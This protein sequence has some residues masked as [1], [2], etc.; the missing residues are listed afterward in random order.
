M[1]NSGPAM[2]RSRRKMAIIWEAVLNFA[3]LL[4]GMSILIF[5]RNSRRPEMKIS[6]Q[7]MTMTG[8]MSGSPIWW[9]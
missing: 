9:L 5:P 3:R 4:T 8:M 2:P 6:R 1:V 7:S